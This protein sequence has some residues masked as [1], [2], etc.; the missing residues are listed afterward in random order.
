MEPI[1]SISWDAACLFDDDCL[2]F[3]YVD[4]GHTYDDVMKD[5]VAWWPKIK[6]GSW[7]GGDDYTKGYPGLM[8]AVQEFF[9][10]KK[11]KVKKLGRC[12]FIRKP[13]DYASN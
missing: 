7:F 9:N 3:C 10:G 2:D 6:S 5:L 8:T 1:Q 12:W 4:A 11:I 13:E